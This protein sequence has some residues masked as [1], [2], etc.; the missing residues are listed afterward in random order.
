MLEVH[1][2]IDAGP[3]GFALDPIHWTGFA[4]AKQAAGYFTVYLARRD[5]VPCG[6]VGFRRTAHLL[7]LKNLIVAPT[8]RRRG[9]GAAILNA[10]AAM[11][12][13]QGLAAVGCFALPGEA[14]E[15]L[16]RRGGFVA[17][18]SQMGW[19]RPLTG[20]LPPRLA[21]RRR[22]HAFS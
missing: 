13:A 11:A 17:T 4:K 18:T 5:G 10:A 3:D 8:H 2:G 9:V 21:A 20:E 7:R 15:A 12:H 22:V 16:Y 19:D 14:G 6:A 1:S